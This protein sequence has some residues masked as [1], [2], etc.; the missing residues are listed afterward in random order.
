MTVGADHVALEVYN[1]TSSTLQIDNNAAVTP[2]ST[3]P[4]TGAGGL[5]VGAQ[6]GG[7]GAIANMRYYG[8][9][10]IGRLLTTVEM[11]SCRSF[12]GA[13]AGLLL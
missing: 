10:Q 5:I 13:K 8:S 6:N 3:G 1:I 2:S 7:S 12:F 4:G 11:N 9:I